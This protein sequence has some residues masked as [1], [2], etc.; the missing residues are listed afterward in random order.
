MKYMLRKILALA[1]VV[2]TIGVATAQTNFADF[3]IKAKDQDGKNLSGVKITMLLNNVEVNSDTTDSDGNVGFTTLTPGK[4]DVKATKEGF[5]DQEIKG[6]SLA[7]GMNADEE[8]VFLKAG[9]GSS[10]GPAVVRVKGKR[11]PVD[12]LKSESVID[13]AKILNSGQRGT[14]L[15]E[16]TNSAILSTPQ[17]ISVRGTRADGNGTF[18]DGQRVSGGG[19]L[20]SLGTEQ[21]SANVGGIPAMYGD[22]TG[23]VFASTTKSA[24]DKVVTVLEGITST[25]L[26]PFGYN[27][28][29]GF[30]SGPIWVKEEKDPS[31]GK[32]KRNLKLG[33][34]LV[35]DLGYFK[36]QAPTR[37]GV[38]R[39]NDAK[40]QEIENN[41]LVYT[42]NGFVHSANYLR[43]NDFE[44]LKAR[45]NSAGGNGNFMGKLE[46]RPTQGVSLTGYVKYYYS[47][48]LAA[49]NSIMNYKNNAQS[50]NQT[51]TG[52]LLFTQNFKV[53]KESSIKNAY[54]SVRAE[55]QNSY[56]LGRDAIHGDD[57]F[58][59]GYIGKFQSYPTAV[60]Q[61]ANYDAQQN[62]NKEP[63]IVRDQF[64]NYVQLRNYWEH[65][66]YADSLMTFEASDL[67]P[68]RAK[69]T[70]N[71][72]DYYDSRGFKVQ[73]MNTLL[74]NQ[75]LINGMNP[76]GVYS[77]HGTPGGVTSGYS[78]SN[79]ERYGVFAVGQMSVK[80]KSVGS[81]ERTQ[82]DLQAGF[83]YEQQITRGYGLGANGLWILM[84]QQ[85]NKHISELDLGN[86][87][88]SYDANGQ[89]TDTV[90]YNRL[91]NYGEQSHFDRAFRD[92]LINEGATDVYGN[93]IDERTFVDINS[94]DPSMFSLDM[95]NADELLNNGNGAVSY[96]GYDH[97]G[98]KVIGKPSIEQ[99][100]NNKDKRTIGAFQPVYIAA[101]LQDQ[102]KFK[103][104]VFRVGVRMERYD[105]NQLVLKDPYSLYPIKTAAEVSEINGLS[106][107]H[108]TNIGEE[109]KV[110][111]N[112]IEAPTKIIGYRNG[113][114]WF[115][116]D[117]SEL[118]S[119]E[120]LANQTSN[121]RI[122][123]YLV[124][125]N[126]LELTK[127]ALEDFTPALNLL[128]RIWFSFPLEP[129]RKSF[130]VSYDVLAQR[131]N[132]AA[133]F[134]TIDELYY[135][136]NRQ[137]ST[138][139]NGSL[140]PRIK[141]DYEVGYKQIFGTKKDRGLEIAASYSENR[142]D[143]GLYQ[144]S[145][146]YPVTYTTYRNID[147]STI[148]GFRGT[149]S[150]NDIGGVGAI[151]GPFSFVA[152]YMLQFADGTGSNI[153][154]QAALIAS[155]QP[156]LRNVI[157]LGELDIRHNIKLMATWAYGGGIDPRT[158]K[159]MYLGP[160]VNGKEIFKYASFNVI[161]NSYSGTP[162][163]PTVRPVQVG[164]AD[165]AQIKGVPYGARL[166]WQQ[167]FDINITKGVR[168]NRA[169]NGKPL[170][171]S[172]FFWI[173]N[174]M[175]AR[176]VNSV[177]PFTG[178]AMNDGFINSP[179]GQLLAQN[180][181]D[182]QSYIDLYKIMLASQTGML[183]APRTVRIGVRINFN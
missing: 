100:L 162:Y 28:L 53:N 132:Q 24:T 90:R 21:I 34:V 20:P 22:L 85:M 61:Y 161:S 45:P 179:Q 72:Y 37:T 110:Y 51:F 13:G 67:N 112:D 14:G 170:I 175:N 43:A 148:T 52:Y 127:D 163:T 144:I 49:S 129:E 81:R 169:D 18:V 119:A 181:I 64:G 130:Y 39:V 145:Q 75:G 16:S 178:E 177:Y 182:A 135:L 171:M 126:K 156:N 103:D 6:I 47:T 68:L 95:F 143:F 88:L 136:K 149:F 71:I 125:P 176:N 139:S 118:K 44:L 146:G 86:P 4:Y 93:K 25:G 105:A 147:F 140:Q 57:I 9:S 172:V 138:I 30:I 160:K 106:V 102:F 78:K 94:Y 31:T 128:P 79:A 66:G 73:N 113:D 7:P 154:S 2:M 174:V 54:Y 164:A 165:R 137:G 121:G 17:G 99:F 98:N 141:T 15:L 10:M 183:G 168:F 8:V 76:N 1:L 91:I 142:K 65:V 26:D 38:Y 122:A 104:L 58:N 107:S 3:R 133:S 59:Y 12:F 97:L 180:Q 48:G 60:Y 92:K 173:Q 32:T 50:D 152:S 29:Q 83:Y 74:I 69:Y 41:P 159:N 109:Y 42:P 23:G 166:P 40:L 131:P 63:K 158:K 114:R 84:R 35:G 150:M 155:N 46:W 116:A 157:P 11:A 117:G 27:K 108:P 82:H 70:K 33:Y 87:I 19:E 55:Y 62:P 111:V 124:N 134:L 5:P 153:N 56:T 96:F 151:P 115:N 80:P 77:L 123:P 36:D 167:T 89:F 101:W 120:F